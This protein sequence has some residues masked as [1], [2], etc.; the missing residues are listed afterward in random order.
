MRVLLF[1]ELP[2]LRLGQERLGWEAAGWS[3]QPLA[4]LTKSPSRLEQSLGRVLES[5]VLSP[6]SSGRVLKFP[7]RL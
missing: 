5:L 3:P 2:L 1:L 6:Q 7:D 4:N